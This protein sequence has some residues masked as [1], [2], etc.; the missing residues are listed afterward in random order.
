[1]EAEGYWRQTL[2]IDPN[3]RS[4]HLHLGRLYEKRLSD[5]LAIEHNRRTIRFNPTVLSPYIWLGALYEKKW[6]R[7]EARKV[8]EEALAIDPRFAPALN[9]LAWL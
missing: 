2:E 7:E 9:N 3:L 6:R 5:G 1:M 8:Y 4:A